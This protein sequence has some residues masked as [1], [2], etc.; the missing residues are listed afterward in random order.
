MITLEQVA[1]RAGCSVSTV[2]RVLNRTGP[3]SA[4]MVRKVRRAAAELGYRHSTSKAGHGRQSRP[5]VG[6]LVPSISNPVFAASL[7]GIQR[8]LQ[9]AG[10]SVL[11]A[12]SNYDP[13]I[14]TTA[15]ASLLEEHPTGLILTL[16]DPRCSDVLSAALPPTVLLNNMPMPRFPAA[17]TVD[18]F[19]ASYELVN[20]L[21]GKGHD[22]I[23]FVS[24]RFTSSDRARLRY[25]GYCQA[26]ADN[27]HEPLEAMQIDFLDGYENLD[28]F[29][30]V[31]NIRPSAIIASNDLLALGVIAALRRHGLSVPDDISVCGF[32]GI[33]IGRLLERPLTTIRMPDADMGTAAA[34]L[35]LDIAQNA[36]PPRHLRVGHQLFAGATVARFQ[37]QTS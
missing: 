23:L 31:E 9:A 20:F 22:R 10:H 24:G 7:A 30:V 19:Q 14:E 12:Q 2:S 11:I 3:V 33:S 18:N 5:V 27:G 8:R 4:E 37:P 1:F 26:L 16:C 13:S 17:V 6:V 34:A 36:A 32:D 35:L 21:T 15:V 28:L 29:D 25:E